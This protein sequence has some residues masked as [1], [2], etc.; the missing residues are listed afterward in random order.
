MTN[1][2]DAD[3]Q[4]LKPGKKVMLK[5][6]L[7]LQTASEKIEPQYNYWALIGSKASVANEAQATSKPERLNQV[8]VTFDCDIKTKGLI[9]NIE[10]SLWIDIADL[11]FVCRY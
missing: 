2:C 9:S 8:L 7:G 4:H 1:I 5:S 11:K 6:F 3:V 10:N